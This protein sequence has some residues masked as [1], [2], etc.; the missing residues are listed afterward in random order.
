MFYWYAKLKLW[1][2]LDSGAIRANFRVR[3]ASSEAMDSA[4][5]VIALHER[6]KRSAP[7]SAPPAGLHE[8][9]MA[10]V[11]SAVPCQP[12]AHRSVQQ[13][14]QSHRLRFLIA[15][16][17][18]CAVLLLGPVGVYLATR[19]STPPSSAGQPVLAAA[20]SALAVS[21]R[22]SRAAP[23]ALVS[24]MERELELIGRDI[25]STRQ[26]LLASLP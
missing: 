11:R 24:P 16:S 1:L 14:R 15:A 2:S 13:L 9:I 21:D 22:L 12:G 19:E 7:Q 6:L 8:S 3:T 20:E 26:L 23:L 5:E 10:V 17:A 4:D 18:A 25:E